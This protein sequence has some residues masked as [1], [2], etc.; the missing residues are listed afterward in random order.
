MRLAIPN[1]HNWVCTTIFSS[2]SGLTWT[3]LHCSFIFLSYL[4]VCTNIVWFLFFTEA[5]RSGAKFVERARQ[6][7]IAHEF[8][9]RITQDTTQAYRDVRDLITRHIASAPCALLQNKLRL[10]F[11]EGLR[12]IPAAKTSEYGTVANRCKS[13]NL[14][15]LSW[16]LRTFSAKLHFKARFTP[17]N[18][19]AQLYLFVPYALL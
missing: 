13:Y 2:C 16:Q 19:N 4:A 11:R 1:F 10:S 17:S 8:R 7:C 14:G 9:T 3:L 5:F 6:I 15:T 18:I 12:S